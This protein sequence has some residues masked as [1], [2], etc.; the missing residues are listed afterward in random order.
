M[1]DFTNLFI[2]FIAA[3]L[4]GT[5]V[6]RIL[7]RNSIFLQIGIIWISNI[8]FT[9][10]NS[11]IHYKYPEA[12]PFIFALTSGLSV[13]AISLFGVSRWVRKPLNNLVQEI[14][15][16]SK[17]DL[18]TTQK[19][20]FKRKHKGELNDLK[21]SI[22]ELSD[23]FKRSLTVISSS[24]DHVNHM[25]IEANKMAQTLS[26]DTNN[27]ASSLEEIS[28]SI[29][30]MNANINSANH[31]ASKT[32]KSTEVTN[33]NILESAK[34][35]KELYNAIE[36]ITL[37]IKVI[38]EIALQTNLLALNAG[39]EAKQAGQAGKGFT[40]VAAEV[41]KLA[42]MSKNAADEIKLIAQNN[43]ILSEQV[44]NKM[45]ETIPKMQETMDLME[46]ITTASNELKSGSDQ[47]TS[48]I[49]NINT[50]TQSNS[51]ISEAMNDN[52]AKM[53][54]ESEK[55]IKSIEYFKF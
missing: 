28:A 23:I 21:E 5:I 43:L 26:E 14:K 48:V 1:G 52:S 20:S 32:Y 35:A 3:V 34:S 51:K 7:F 8:F 53:N 30:Q 10:I 33:I 39:I 50:N 27:Q 4:T 15:N 29:E 55:L 2:T 38:D 44:S 36:T 49:N 19:I 31:N 18:K 12:Y 40:V 47:V 37:K 54:K 46:E 17:G 25:G 13:T 9:V 11:K 16:L 45:N 22:L 24:A 41:K 6:L 42:D